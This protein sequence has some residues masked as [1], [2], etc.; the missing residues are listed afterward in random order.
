MHRV[1]DA[2]VGMTNVGDVI[3]QASTIMGANEVHDGSDGR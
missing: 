3:D 2:T 1:D